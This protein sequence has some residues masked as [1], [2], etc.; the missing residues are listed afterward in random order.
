M[1]P[2]FLSGLTALLSP[3]PPAGWS[4]G[5]RRGRRVAGGRAALRAAALHG[6]VQHGR[7]RPGGRRGPG[8]RHR[9]DRLSGS[10]EREPALSADGMETGGL[11]DRMEGVF[12]LFKLRC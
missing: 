10:P 3:P 7:L 11:S 5:A 2:I 1:V 8:A 4:G 6:L 12:F 9:A